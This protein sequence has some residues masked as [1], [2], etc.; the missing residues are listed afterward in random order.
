MS[1][2]AASDRI[3]GARLEFAAFEEAMVE[4]QWKPGEARSR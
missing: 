1:V 4:R 2:A 3:V